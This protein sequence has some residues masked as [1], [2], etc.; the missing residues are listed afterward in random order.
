MIIEEHVDI[1]N[2]TTLKLPARASFFVRL[3]KEEDLTETYQFLQEHKLSPFVL[4]EGSNV[5]VKDLQNILV[6]K[7]EIHGIE[8][9]GNIFEV[10]A[11]ENWDNFVKETVEQNFV[12]LAPLSFIPGT[13][14]G[15][16]VQNIGAYGKEVGEYIQK[17]RAFDFE[18]GAFVNFSKE[19]CLFSYRDSIFKKYSKRFCITKIIF[20]LNPEEVYVSN[21]PLV[22]DKIKTLDLA[23]AQ[24]VR[25]V[26]IET[27]QS[28]LPYWKEIAN[29]G[30]FFKN[31]EVSKS[32]G[33]ML[34]NTFENIPVFE[35]SEAFVKLSAGWLIE[36]AGLKGFELG[37][38]KTYEKHALVIV[39]NGKGNYEELQDFIKIIRSKVQEKFGVILEQEPIEI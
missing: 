2:F 27:R 28:K 26:I 22:S 23:K 33:E 6:I 37:N 1:T 25:D 12:C 5:V 10:G 19:E 13:C 39:H 11:G 3:T 32:V 29:V 15:A 36:N 35:I 30:S 34:K 7:N 16:P 38:F 31:P 14:G 17:V 24:D 18:Q 8:H 20:E 9:N 4:G 21:Y